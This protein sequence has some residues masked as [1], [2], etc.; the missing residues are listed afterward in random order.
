MAEAELG[1]RAAL[2]D[3]ESKNYKKAAAGV[4]KVLKK[5]PLHSQSYAL[6]ALINAFYHPGTP[7]SK[8]VNALVT[9][10]DNILKESN[11]L[12]EKA[13]KYGPSNSISA[14]LAALYYRH[15]KDYPNATQ[16]YVTAYSSNPNNKAILRDLSS[17][18]AQQR[19]YNPLTKTRLDYLQAEP[20]YRTNFSSTATA[21]DL[22]GEPE[23]AIKICDQI[24]DIIKDK[25][26][27]EDK[28]ENS[29]ALIYKATLMV[30]MGEDKEALKYVNS[31]LESTENFRCYDVFGLLEMK[32]KLLFK[33]DNYHEAQLTIRALLKRNP[34]NLQYYQDL[35]KAL[36][37]ENDNEKELKLFTKLAKFYPKA[38]LPSFLPLTFLKGEQFEA[39]LKSYLFKLFQ[40]GVPSI[41]SNI[42]SLYK[43]KSNIPVI[44]KTVES[45]E[46]TEENPLILTWIKYFLS[47][48]YYKLKDYD[49]AMKQ[50]D[51]GIKITPTLIE[52]YMFKA[53]IY[54]HQGKLV[55]AVEEMDTARLMDLQDR[56][57]NSK[58]VKYFL[59]A[60]NIEK[61]LDVASLFTKNDDE[62][63]G[64]KDL[65]MV[66]CCWFI[67][68][69]AE[70]LTRLF[71]KSLHQFETLSQKN[72]TE[73]KDND[74]EEEK[75][76]NIHL[77]QREVE[78]YLGL[79]LQRYLSIFAIYA[80]YYEDQFDFH[81][82]SHR[83]G[84]LRSYLEMI[85]WGDQLYHQQFIGRIYSDI[86]SLVAFASENEDSLKR[87]FDLSTS[88]SKRSKKEKKEEI[89]WKE[90]MVKYNKVYDSDVFGEQL[91]TKI[92][93][94]KD[95][96]KL[97]EIEKHITRMDGE[98]AKTDI[99]TL[100]FLNGEFNYEFI[101][102]KYVVALASLRKVKAITQKAGE[103]SEL[104]EMILDDMMT[105]INKFA[106]S[107]FEDPKLTSLQKVVK[108]GLTRI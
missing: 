84:T 63:T 57:V 93:K 107:S 31:L 4:E 19:N 105:R 1:F 2:Q 83:K 21:Y 13:M 86:M 81:F 16:Y 49:S 76:T 54:K 79:A 65:H 28:Y 75:S 3:Y 108:L 7:D 103:D 44:L 74:D 73:V 37:I 17:C 9:I 70:S 95:Y 30:K 23:K 45:F 92:I 22:N 8:D 56:F 90:N 51:E 41:F 72:D 6:K 87:A 61:A 96:S 64:V 29:E 88:T 38:D 99:D 18:L 62:P 10:P 106:N 82:Y 98:C 77:V 97:T 5:N 14:H 26:I 71:K 66:Q 60:D 25:L 15:I 48:H 42:K 39:H 24:E 100:Y 32:Y 46:A 36:K 69:Y 27:D 78:V 89:K 50:I 55:E 102:G 94:Q 80:E 59:R 43:R 53:R 67:S 11:E 12:I 35:V 58:T 91:V 52:L 85:R 68:E 20:G 40:R 34:D 33:L 104:A 47:Q 101:S